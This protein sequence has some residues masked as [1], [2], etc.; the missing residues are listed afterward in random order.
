MAANFAYL[1]QQVT[2]KTKAK[3]SSG[4]KHLELQKALKAQAD[5]RAAEKRKSSITASAIKN[6]GE[7]Q[8]AS[9]KN[10]KDKLD[11]IQ[12]QNELELQ[13]ECSFS[14]KQTK[15]SQLAKQKEQMK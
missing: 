9:I 7:R 3:K 6:F 5:K 14:P 10:K 13:E 1:S 8:D 12:K 4:S 2:N 11:K 15:L